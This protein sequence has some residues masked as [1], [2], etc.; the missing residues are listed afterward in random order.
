MSLE[1]ILDMLKKDLIHLGLN[2]KETKKLQTGHN[3]FIKVGSFT[4][5]FY[6]FLFFIFT[7]L[8]LLYIESK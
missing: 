4:I 7:K 3:K 2:K 1:K 6:C 5:Y 8:G